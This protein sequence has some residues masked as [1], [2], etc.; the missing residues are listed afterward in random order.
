MNMTCDDGKDLANLDDRSIGVIEYL[1]DR[2]MIVPLRG[3]VALNPGAQR[4]HASLFS[5]ASCI[6]QVVQ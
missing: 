3:N 6:V 5:L 4:K 1:I 2:C